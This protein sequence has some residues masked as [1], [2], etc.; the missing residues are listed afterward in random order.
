MRVPAN[1]A[2]V[3]EL[4]LERAAE[5]WGSALR[6]API[7]VGRWLGCDAPRLRRHT[8]MSSGK[9]QHV[10][11]DLSR[12]GAKQFESMTQSL[13]VFAVGAKVSVFGSGPD[14]GREATWEGV[15][16]ALGA[17][18]EWNGFGVL[19]SKYKE[20]A[21]EPAA[22][23]KWLKTQIDLEL[24]AWADPESLR[25][26][27]P[28]VYLVATNVRLSPGSGGGK[29]QILDFVNQLILELGLDI[30]AFRVWDAD[31]LYALLD[32]A[33][34]VRR[35][36]T[37][38]ITPGD[39][40]S[41]VLEEL[42][43][44]QTSLVRAIE[45]YTAMVMRDE[46]LLN[47]TQAGSVK[48]QAISVADV[49][50][51]LPGMSSSRHIEWRVDDDGP[52]SGIANWLIR[53]A[54]DASGRPDGTPASKRTVL[55][56]GPG[57]GKS[58]LTQFVAQMYRSTF[59]RESGALK[60]PEVGAI[61]ESLHERR[62][63][64]AIPECAA[65]RWPFRI[66]L[67]D[68]AD[69]LASGGCRDIFE[70]IANKVSSRASYQ[71]DPS[72]IRRW[73]QIWPW[74]L[75]IDGLDEVPVSSN[76]DQVMVAVKDFYTEVGALESD[77]VTVATTRPQGY[78]DDFH[79]RDHTHVV[80]MPLPL[81]TAI[82]YARRFIEIR[83]GQ[84]TEAAQKTVD[85][86]VR[87]SREEST[88]RLFKSPL[89]VTILA[90]L[91]EKLGQVPRDRWRLFSQYY[92]VVTQREQEKGG[93]LA[94]LLQRHQTDVDFIHRLVGYKLQKRSAEAGET[95]ST[96]S[97]EEF[98][99]LVRR[100]LVRQ[101]YEDHELA[102]L[103]SQFMALA[104]HRLV[105]LES[106]TA[107]RVGFEIRSLQEFMAGEQIVSLPEAKIV[108][109]LRSIAF[110]PHWRNTFLFAVG[111]VFADREHLRAE[112]VLL[113]QDLS[114]RSL[115]APAL[116]LGGWLALEILLDGS[117]LAQPVYARPLVEL[118]CTLID[119]PAV[120][121]IT[122][123]TEV[124]SAS[125][126]ESIRQSAADTSA[127]ANNVWV[128]RVRVL[129]AWADRG[130]PLAADDLERVLG[131]VPDAPLQ[132]LAALA[133]YEPMPSLAVALESQS[134]RLSLPEVV[135]LVT[136]DHP[137]EF[138]DLTESN[139][140][141]IT[142]SLREILAH[143]EP[144]IERG[145]RFGDVRVGGVVRRIADNGDAWRHLIATPLGSGSE[146]VGMIAAFELRPSR[147]TLASAIERLRSAD[148]AALRF[149]A[150]T[151]SW[152][153]RGA[154]TV[155]DAYSR[156]FGR[157]IQ[158]WLDEIA[159]RL[160]AGELGDLNE[161]LLAQ[162]RWDAVDS[163]DVLAHEFDF[164]T[165]RAGNDWDV[166]VC[167]RPDFLPL[168]GIDFQVSQLG[169]RKHDL[170]LA[171]TALAEIAIRLPSSSRQG[172]L[173][174]VA[175]FIASLSVG[176]EFSSDT[177]DGDSETALLDGLCPLLLELEPLGGRDL[178]LWWVGWLAGLSSGE[179]DRLLGMQVVEQWGLFPRLR[180]EPNSR[181]ADRIASIGP[182]GVS[183]QSV[184]LAMHFDPT[185]VRR[186]PR[187]E[188]VG[189]LDTAHREPVLARTQSF[190]RIALASKSEMRHGD[191]DEDIRV[192]VANERDSVGLG[193]VRS[194]AE[195][196]A[197][198][199]SEALLLRVLLVLNDSEPVRGGLLSRSIS[200]TAAR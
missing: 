175:F 126:D 62:E 37:A 163:A 71:V 77:V 165:D 160:R 58:T 148:E 56:G 41:A 97:R 87:A 124:G 149:V 98:E 111:A 48:D 107:D 96:L 11:Y 70:Y 25:A 27:K 141:T 199:M 85:R 66:V 72:D 153:L 100:R 189:L 69:A 22:N 13:A 43:R 36:Y 159:R 16:P 146:V 120:S 39:V 57:Q 198:S 86:L 187:D 63:E 164:A 200:P 92:R 112:V 132:S 33:D 42:G 162:A 67:T 91:L 195:S 84:G 46:H 138:A 128:N 122:Q 114:R 31:D 83:N 18:D 110:S 80:L 3:H 115:S 88:Q 194:L 6:S 166:Q 177:G 19:Q 157:S 108:P 74:I 192:V 151:S 105:F 142:S 147:S 129:A 154:F 50:V 8:G 125:V 73:V 24:R 29:D 167:A 14:G 65:R 156:R 51:D 93:Q 184:R 136:A 190:L 178:S 161:W 35:A 186:L 145:L 117:P 119:G 183:I 155:A 94:E 12:L 61:A 121:A 102:T 52:R 55:V 188:L 5:A 59:L 17:G 106:S 140:R 81:K 89:Q 103:V 118:V 2:H 23:L 30:R 109:R 137:F 40:L 10:S 26:R 9:T 196:L 32:N 44:E 127:A 168:A 21:T 135:E 54:D 133:I 60:V 193:M 47:L 150:R 172:V 139:P 64:L 171:S 15:S 7:Q 116:K 123:L 170:L 90:I 20:F 185:I 99:R 53:R 38:F 174:D 173:R 144:D 1:A 130:H 68:L 152:V 113:C 76:R 179:L 28:D 49:F 34:S 104:T 134:H 197:P 75:F 131:C 169:G 101:G 45:S 158:D 82:D 182:G 95:S 176:H 191:R 78:D 4:V 180:G 181:V 143:R 79:P